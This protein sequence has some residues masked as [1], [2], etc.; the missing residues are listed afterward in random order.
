MEGWGNRREGE[1]RR[2]RMKGNRRG[3]GGMIGKEENGG[4][5]GK[6]DYTL[7]GNIIY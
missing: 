1:D 2:D 7:E 6:G 3:W 5:G 4:E